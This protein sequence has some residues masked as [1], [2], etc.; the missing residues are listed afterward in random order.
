MVTEAVNAP[1]VVG[2]KCPWMVQLAPAATLDPQLLA[3]TNEEASAPVNTML[4]MG[5]ADPLVFFIV[6]VCELLVKPTVVGGKETL[7]ADRDTA[8]GTKPVPFNAID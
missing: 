5:N 8:T 4:L 2:A 1:V 6:T 3:K 7:V